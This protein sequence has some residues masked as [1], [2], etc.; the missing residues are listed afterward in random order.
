MVH[1][2]TVLK[3]VLAQCAY[4]EALSV[5]PRVIRPAEV[6]IH[7]ENLVS[8]QAAAGSGSVVIPSPLNL[9]TLRPLPSPRRGNTKRAR[10]AALQLKEE[11]TLYWGSGDGTMAKLQIRMPGKGENIVNLEQIDDMVR[12]VECPQNDTGHLKIRFAEEADFNDAQDIW[13]W[14]K[15]E[16]DNHFIMIVGEGACNGTNENRI[17]YSV[18]DLVYNDDKET[19]VLDVRRTTW[20]ATIHTFDLTVGKGAVVDA[21]PNAQKRLRRLRRSSTRA[22]R[23]LFDKV[24]DAVKDTASGVADKIGDAAD[25][26]GNTVT[27]AAHGAAD[28]VTGV[29]GTVGEAVADG[30]GEVGDVVAGTVGNAGQGASTIGDAA[31][32]ILTG[33]ASPEF[34]VPFSSDFSGESLA[35]SKSGVDVTASCSTCTTTGFFDVSGRFR[36]E[37]FDLKEAW[38]ELSTKGINA[39]AVIGLTVK[40]MLTEKLADASVP[41]FKASPAGVTLTLG[42]TA[43]IPPSTSRLDFLSKDGLIADGWEPCFEKAPFKSDSFVEAKAA[44]RGWPRNQCCW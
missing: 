14:V 26:V 20:K 22:R 35:F 33:D 36:A 10:L 2:R 41:V 30:A 19:A 5:Q 29:A 40:G 12:D 34:S 18:T 31:D 8:P 21:V 6:D 25:A 7:A 1:L 24:V 32:A 3:T 11:E 37:L 17:V 39:T 38:I 15:Q 13:E 43:T 44:V 9:V 42:G 28:A 16:E 23:G 4:I 27:G